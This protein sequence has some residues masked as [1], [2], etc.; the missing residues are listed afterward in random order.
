[1]ILQKYLVENYVNPIS[2]DDMCAISNYSPSRLRTIFKEELNTSPV[3]Y[4]RNIRLKHAELLLLET[5]VNVNYIASKVG[6]E[7]A[8]YFCR[9]FQSTHNMTPTEYRKLYSKYSV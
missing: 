1:M 5:D 9:L 8:T 7:N 6:F 2:I 3:Q 4:L